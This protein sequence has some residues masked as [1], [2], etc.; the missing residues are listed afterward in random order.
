MNEQNED[1]RG[2]LANLMVHK[3][4]TADRYY[5]LKKKGKSAVKTSK[6]LTRIMRSCSS[7]DNELAEEESETSRPQCSSSGN[8]TH[9][10]TSAE[11]KELETAFSSNIDSHSI[12]MAEVRKTVKTNPLLKNISPNKI[13]DKI[14]T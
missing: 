5:L 10:W 8:G 4:S 12:S 2:D 9:S 6:E 11:I 1:M 3:Q 13:R 14:R 7:K